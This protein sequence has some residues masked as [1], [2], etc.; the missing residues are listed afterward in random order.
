MGLMLLTYLFAADPSTTYY[1]NDTGS[2]RS[3]RYFNEQIKLAPTVL[4]ADTQMTVT[5]LP[6]LWSLPDPYT[7][8]RC[9]LR[10]RFAARATDACL[11]LEHLPTGR[12]YGHAVLPLGSLA[13]FLKSAAISAVAM[14]LGKSR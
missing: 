14:T 9:R 13:C 1:R 8:I 7:R 11:T 12:C 6:A 4:A 5:R 10:E 2:A 3:C